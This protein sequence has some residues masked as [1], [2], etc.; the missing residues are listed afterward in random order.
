[1]VS[2]C[3][4]TLVF[5]VNWVVGVLFL[6]PTTSSRFILEKRGHVSRR[7]TTAPVC[8]AG[9]PTGISCGCRQSFI[10]FKRGVRIATDNENAP[11]SAPTKSER[12]RKR[13][14]SPH[15]E[16]LVHRRSVG[17]I[18]AVGPPSD[19]VYLGIICVRL[20]KR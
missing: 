7:Q 14:V 1:M 4:F 12:A 13:I 20:I 19:L 10:I 15:T 3:H 5:L 16:R 11:D 18:R 17:L 9:I 6:P 2:V 8:A